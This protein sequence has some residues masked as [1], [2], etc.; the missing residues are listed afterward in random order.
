MMRRLTAQVVAGVLN[1]KMAAMMITTR[2]MVLHTACETSIK[3]MRVQLKQV[4]GRYL[5][6]G[7]AC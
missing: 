5:L 7:D 6:C 4:N 3:I 1:T 2:F